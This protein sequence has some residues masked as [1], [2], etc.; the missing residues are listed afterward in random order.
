MRLLLVLQVI[1]TTH[2]EV[3]T[4]W[5]A[6]AVEAGAQFR[7]VGKW[8]Y[9]LCFLFG[10]AN[11]QVVVPVGVNPIVVANPVI[12]VNPV[13]IVEPV[14]VNPVIVYSAAA[15]TIDTALC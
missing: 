14:V 7:P 8:C 13:A 6:S 3:A 12:I 4:G 5:G 2:H 10:R 15:T 11:N 9:Q 1:G